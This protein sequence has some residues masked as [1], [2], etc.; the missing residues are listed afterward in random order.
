MSPRP[1]A[2]PHESPRYARNMRIPSRYV[3]MVF[4]LAPFSS[5]SLLRKNPLT[6][7]GSISS[8]VMSRLLDQCESL[9]GGAE[10]L[11]RGLEI[12]GGVIVMG[13]AHICGK[14]VH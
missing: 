11:R 9:G 6:N 2:G 8:L 5:T 3:S 1:K 7:F 13:V 4:L 12:V 14:N 10:D